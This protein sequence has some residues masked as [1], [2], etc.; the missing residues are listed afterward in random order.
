[1]KNGT[2]KRLF[3]SSCNN[4]CWPKRCVKY[5]QK[6]ITQKSRYLSFGACFWKVP[7]TFRAPKACKAGLFICCKGDKN[8]N[9]WKVSCLETPAFKIKR[10]LCHPKCSRKFSGLSRDGLL[11]L[12]HQ[13]T[14]LSKFRIKV[15]ANNDQS[16]WAWWPQRFWL[17]LNQVYQVRWIAVVFIYHQP[18][19]FSR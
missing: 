3:S 1:M 6:S 16:D 9:D 18:Q 4:Y 17:V 8:E 15:P 7:E 5:I 11:A 2:A 14:V 19:P 12:A 10:E 13:F